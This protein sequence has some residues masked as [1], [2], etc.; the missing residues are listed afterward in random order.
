MSEKN[1]KTIAC[2]ADIH[3]QASD[4]GKWRDFFQ[5][6]SRQADVLLIGGDLT[7]AGKAAEAEVL[8]SE[9]RSCGI[10][11]ACVM[12]NHDYEAGEEDAIMAALRSEQVHV[13]DGEAVVLNGVGIAGIKGF[14]GGF[15]RYMM[16]MYGEQINKDFVQETASEAL[17]LDQALVKLSGEVEN[18]R[19]VALM[20]YAPVKGTVVGEPEE[21][22]PFLGS[23]RLADP[24]NRRKVAA[25]FHGHAHIGTLEGK[26]SEGVP[27]YNVAM[28]I[29]R[30]EGYTPPVF[31][32]EL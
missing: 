21:I 25:A 17:K 20:H 18:D 9:L 3:V 32:Y 11:V 28:H 6:V 19:I 13:L 30:K 15:D 29:L 23:S 8:A 10:P 1:K 12:G 24:L 16:P 5:D 22:F 2:L 7:Y 31:Y 27:V 26:T 14:G 4:E